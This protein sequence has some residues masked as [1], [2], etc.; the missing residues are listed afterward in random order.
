MK[1]KLKTAQRDSVR[2]PA[3]PAAERVCIF[4]R[5]LTHKGLRNRRRCAHGQTNRFL[6][7]ERG[8][9]ARDQ[10]RVKIRVGKR[11]TAN[12]VAQKLH[13]GIEAHDAGLR[14]RL[15]KPGQ[16][17][18]TGLAMHDQLGDHRIIKR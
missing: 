6:V 14:Q 9:L 13:I 2:L 18:F 7:E 5:P 10:R 12:D 17:F 4:L 8:L 15:I 3:I 11:I 1:L 16:R